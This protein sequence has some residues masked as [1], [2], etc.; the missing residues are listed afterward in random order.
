MLKKIEQDLKEAI[1]SK[2][3]ERVWT[4]RMLIASL[5]NKE[6]E[7]RPKKQKLSEEIEIEV[8]KQEIKKRKEAIEMF[9]KGNREDLVLK[10]KKELEILEKYLPKQLS[11]DELKELVNKIKIKIKAKSR[12]E[13]G[14]TTGAE[15][16]RDF[17]K[18][19][20][21]VMKEVKGRADGLRVKKMVEEIL[22]NK[23]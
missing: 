15:S 3:T 10:E 17:G 21:A 22:K 11:D 12:S 7:L 5:K 9:K 1:L 18:L 13:L 6:I 4:L 20:G 23:R 16:P 14:S 2:Q 8:I 19:M